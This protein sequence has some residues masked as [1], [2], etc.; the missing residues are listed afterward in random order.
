MANVEGGAPVS[1]WDGP[2][3]PRQERIARRLFTQIGPGPA[4]FFRDACS[5]GSGGSAWPSVT[6][7]VG[8]L[9]REI[10]SAVLWVLEPEHARGR[11]QAGGHKA[12]ILAILTGLEISHD[13]LV[14]EYW[15]GF[16]GQG[17]ADSL[18]TRAHRNALDEPRPF[19][20]EFAT[21][22]DRFEQV[23][24]AVLER[25]EINYFEIFGRL[26]ELLAISSPG[27]DHADMLRQRFPRTEAVAQYFF[28]RAP[29][30]WVGPLHR[31]GFFARPPSALIDEDAG[32]V[33]FPAWPLSQFLAR[34]AADAPDAVVAAVRTMAATD[35]IRVNHDLVEIAAAL[36]VAASAELVP[37]IVAALRSRYGIL[38][39]QRVG[40]L[41]SHLCSGG[42]FAP[43]LDLAAAMFKALSV[44]YGPAASVHGYAYGEVLMD[45]VPV[46]V[47]AAGLPALSLLCDALDEVVRKDPIRA[48]LDSAEDGSPIW[49]PSIDGHGNR[50]DTDLRHS[51]VDAVRDAASSLVDDGIASLADVVSELES[52]PCVIFRRIALRLLSRYPA[53]APDLVAERLTD[54]AISADWRLELEYLLLARRGAAGLGFAHLRRLLTLID[55][56]PPPRR[57]AETAA[58]D[59]DADPWTR[60]RTARWQRNRLASIQHVLP[61][62]WDARYQALVAEFGPAPDPDAPGPEMFAFRVDESPV[63]AGDLAAMPTDALVAFLKTGQLPGQSGQVISPASVRGVLSSAIQ[64]D[65]E[66]RS[67]DAASFIGLHAEYVGAVLNGL[68]QATTNGNTLDWAGV[69]TLAAWINQQASEELSDSAHA[70]PRTWRE[71][72]AD[73]LRLLIAGLN[74]EPSPIRA[75]Q[76]ADIWAIIDNCCRDSDPTAEREA[77]P[78]AAPDTPFVSLALTA[79]RAQAVHAAISYGLR[80]RRQASDAGLTEVQEVLGR[81]LDSGTER[82][83]AVRSVYGM[84][85]SQLAWM[86]EQWAARHVEAIFTKDPSEVALLTTAWDAYL[87]GGRPTEAA[88]PLLTST[89]S[90]MTDR[91]D[92]TA[93]DRGENF[94]ATQLG[95]HLVARLWAGRLDL[96]SHDGLLRRFYDRAAPKVA[97]QLMSWISEGFSSLER[98]DQALT[99]R[100]TGF[101]EYRV[102]AVKNGA[103][104]TELTA[105]G[106]W[107]ASGHFSPTWSLRQLL[108]VLS[109]AD[110]LEAEDIVLAYLADLAADH[111]QACLAVLERWISVTPHPWMLT[112]CLDSIRQT[113]AAGMAGK[114]TAINTSKRIISLLLRDH[115]ID[116]RDVLNGTEPG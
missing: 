86:D 44:G 59:E 28:S 18:A 83:L 47:T 103:D 50:S 93:P 101:W 22:F 55:G 16:A 9:M 49:R 107:F 41:A 53:Q 21:Y 51:L 99:A 114:P 96:D 69:I 88:W 54:A 40:V 14:A 85:F 52:H 43:A 62:E 32:T 6:H 92:L 3:S 12:K 63:T 8:H 77:E 97:A 7:L 105:F 102:A 61:P 115:G 45:H 64:A 17:S 75:N 48:S 74:L 104:A 95:K 79:V 109:L 33:Q 89:Y 111:T 25:F 90:M 110:R 4:A 87:T 81:H 30:A 13:D 116:V 73:M 91:M 26:E 84:L 34:V 1:P 5:L 71:P 29:A 68:W 58:G 80:L 42:Q 67:A 56:G 98:P 19:S 15:L 39:P 57:W 65:P 24:D 72:R 76:A 46:L 37:Q 78:M 31:N 94:Q 38:I 11:N 66:H 82:S 2:F 113:L 36:P 70:G 10:E 100:M 112:Q 23:L 60:D 27:N 106:R 35:N 108:T 20:D